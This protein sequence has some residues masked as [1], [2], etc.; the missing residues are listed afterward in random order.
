MLPIGVKPCCEIQWSN[1]MGS[2][3][4]ELFTL[5]GCWGQS[6]LASSMSHWSLFAPPCLHFAIVQAQSEGSGNQKKNVQLRYRALKIGEA[7][8]EGLRR[9][10]LASVASRQLLHDGRR[11]CTL[12]GTVKGSFPFVIHG[13]A[14]SWHPAKGFDSSFEAVVK[15]S[16]VDVRGEDVHHPL[17]HG[18]DVQSSEPELYYISCLLSSHARMSKNLIQFVIVLV[19]DSYLLKEIFVRDVSTVAIHSEHLDH[20]LWSAN[21]EAF[22]IN[23]ELSASSVFEDFPRLMRGHSDSSHMGNGFHQCVSVSSHCCICNQRCCRREG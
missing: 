3:H 12:Q 1:G 11:L 16:R 9:K 8:T 7:T 21:L 6:A 18:R 5:L 19:G 17:R 14:G 22:S 20:F 10:I 4:S 13:I 15:V 2:R 23:T